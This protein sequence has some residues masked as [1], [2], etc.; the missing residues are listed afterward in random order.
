[1]KR[2]KKAL[3]MLLTFAMLLALL[4]WAAM[5]ARADTTYPLWVGGTQITDAC[6]SVS[7]GDG[8]AVYAPGTNTLTLTDYSYTGAGHQSMLG[9]TSQYSAAAAIWYEGVAPLTVVLAGESSITQNGGSYGGSCGLYSAGGLTITGDGSLSAASGAAEYYSYGVYGESRDVPAVCI[10]DGMLTATGSQR[11]IC[12]ESYSGS[13]AASG[14]IYLGKTLYGSDGAAYSGACEEI[15]AGTVGSTAIASVTKSGTSWIYPAL[16][17]AVSAANA[18]NSSTLTLLADA[19]PDAPI[20]ITG[21]LALDLND[22]SVRFTGR[23]GSAIIVRDKGELALRDG[24][25]AKTTRYI[26]LDGNGRGTEVAASGR[27]S[28][29][30]IK[31]TG[32]CITGGTAETGGGIDI[33]AGGTLIMSGGTIVG[34]AADVGGGVYADGTLKLS[35]E[36]KITGNTAATGGWTSDTL[37]ATVVAP[38]G[39]VLIAAAYDK[40]GRQTG[41]WTQTVTAK[42]EAQH[43]NTEL[44]KTLGYTYKLMLVQRTSFVPLCSAWSQ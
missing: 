5:P 38:E 34:N 30:C 25:A 26:T 36:A 37:R 33:C 1:M 12:A 6:L 29:N 10:E 4:P 18:A 31:I 17:F 28:A 39:G 13:D 42:S 19:E 22:H 20:E 3:S 9:A 27:E 21:K 16:G 24:A 41:V 35:G 40:D 23:S 2:T 14:E 43:F 7:G 11:G 44:A 32:G 8:T 15:T